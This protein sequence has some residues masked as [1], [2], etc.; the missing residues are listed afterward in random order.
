[1]LQLARGV[2]RR[3][4]L[5]YDRLRFATEYQMGNTAGTVDTQQYWNI[6]MTLQQPDPNLGSTIKAE[7]Q[8]KSTKM[9]TPDGGKTWIIDHVTIPAKSPGAATGRPG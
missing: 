6:T 1:M 8:I 2:R 7:G 4:N 3:A 5:L 9:H